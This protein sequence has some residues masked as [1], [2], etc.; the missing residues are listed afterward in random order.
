MKSIGPCRPAPAGRNSLVR[1]A[2]HGGALALLLAVVLDCRA[3]CNTA[4]PAGA[5][6]SRF[7][8]NGDGTVTDFRTGLMWMRCALGQ[9]WNGATCTGSPTRYSW[10][11][12]LAGAQ[13]DFA[14][15]SDWR[16]P[17]VKELLSIVERR[18]FNPSINETVFPA[19]VPGVY[20]SSTPSVAGIGT[21]A[22]SVS[23]IQGSDGGEDKA[24]LTR[25]VRPVRVFR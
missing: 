8:D 11:D 16:L 18:C 23:F 12:A 21:E 13:A 20:W 14:G 6:T 7:E 4:I 15:H 24:A 10:A 19:T 22:Y 1:A 3:T 9:S 17:N 5:P 25:L 2:L